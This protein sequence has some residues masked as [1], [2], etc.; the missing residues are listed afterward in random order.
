MVAAEDVAAAAVV[1]DAAA[2]DGVVRAAA[3]VVAKEKCLDAVGNAVEDAVEGAGL[4]VEYWR[5]VV[6]GR[7]RR[8]CP[9]SLV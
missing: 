1:K 5:P 7:R 8:P 3:R 4:D 6:N 9:D 2:D